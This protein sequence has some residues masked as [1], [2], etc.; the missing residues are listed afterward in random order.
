M[1]VVEK[2]RITTKWERYELA[3]KLLL[4]VFGT[5]AAPGIVIDSMAKACAACNESVANALD[6][7]SKTAAEYFVKTIMP[8]ELDNFL[9]TAGQSSLSPL[10]VLGKANKNVNWEQIVSLL[11]DPKVVI[12]MTKGVEAA[13]QAALRDYA[14]F[15]RTIEAPR[16]EKSKK[17]LTEED[18][19]RKGDS[20]QKQAAAEVLRQQREGRTLGRTRLSKGTED[21]DDDDDVDAPRSTKKRTTVA[22][23]LSALSELS[24]D[25]SAQAKA[26]NSLAR[27]RLEFERQQAN[28]TAADRAADRELRRAEIELERERLMADRARADRE[29]ELRLQEQQRN[30]Q[31]QLELLKMLVTK[32]NE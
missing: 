28:T 29:F 2:D 24:A 18:A 17:K 6:S 26:A 21:E 10:D 32:K 12:H 22:A 15:R 9:K 8:K 19:K 20:Q 7:K 3:A 14:E 4:D 1:D 16:Q 27:D 11:D 30:T 5:E 23:G 13:Q 25:R 31:F